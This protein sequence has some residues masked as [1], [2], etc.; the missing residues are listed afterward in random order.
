MDGW[1]DTEEDSERR[2]AKR[3]RATHG[4]ERKR[5]AE[6]CMTKRKRGAEWC[7]TNRQKGEQRDVGQRDKNIGQGEKKRKM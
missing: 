7:R 5:I 4:E 3:K 1:T 2:M 6:M